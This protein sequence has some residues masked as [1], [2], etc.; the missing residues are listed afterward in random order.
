VIHYNPLSILFVFVQNMN[1][2]KLSL[3]GMGEWVNA[4]NLLP[5]VCSMEEIVPFQG[6]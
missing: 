5:K 2:N 3:I 4:K 6:D 1:L